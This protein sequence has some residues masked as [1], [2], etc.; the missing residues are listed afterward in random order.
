MG[1]ASE[2]FPLILVL[3]GALSHEVLAGRLVGQKEAVPHGISRCNYPLLAHD[4][5]IH[6]F[7][8]IRKARIGR[9]A[10]SLGAVVGEKG[11]R[12]HGVLLL[13]YTVAIYTGAMCGKVSH[14]H[15]VSA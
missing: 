9:Q 11:A 2:G 12:G 8:G 4:A 14:A 13:L 1:L 10:Y 6:L 5:H 3:A 7:H 15:L